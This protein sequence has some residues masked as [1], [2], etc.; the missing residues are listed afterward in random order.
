MMKCLVNEDRVSLEFKRREYH[1]SIQALRGE[2]AVLQMPVKGQMTG[3]MSE[4]L[5]ARLEIRLFRDEIEIW[6]SHGT[7]AGLDIYGDTTV[8]ESSVWRK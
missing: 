8:L 5:R 7:T 2:T 3:K 1:L 6:A 4:S